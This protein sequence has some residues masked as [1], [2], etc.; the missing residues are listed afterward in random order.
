MPLRE[1][2]EGPWR[3]TAWRAGWRQWV[4][5]RA[6][7]GLRKPQARI[8]LTKVPWLLPSL[9]VPGC[10]HARPGSAAARARPWRQ[11]PCKD[12]RPSPGLWSEPAAPCYPGT[13]SCIR[14]GAAGQRPPPAQRLA[15]KKCS[16]DVCCISERMNPPHTPEDRQGQ[17]T[18]AGTSHDA[19]TKVPSGPILPSHE[20]GVAQ[21]LTCHC[22][23]SSMAVCCLLAD[24]DTA[25]RGWV[26]PLCFRAP[27]LL[28]TG[29]GRE[30]PP[31]LLGQ[32]CSHSAQQ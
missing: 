8:R 10:T 19:S 27:V 32:V 15:Q 20:T 7:A 13:I 18:G 5:Q 3:G 22:W 11:A 31:P 21:T 9:E 25:E 28:E 16:A 1:V 30:V 17:A 23:A 2:S 14:L 29:T 6:P 26:D 12:C 24:G 4:R